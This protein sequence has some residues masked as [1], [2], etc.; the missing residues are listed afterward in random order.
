MA[1]FF[2]PPHWQLPK[3][4]K[5]AFSLRTGGH[6][7]PPYASNNLGLHV[8]DEKEAVLRNREKLTKELG[9]KQVQWLNQVHGSDVCQALA[10]GQLPDVDACFTT[11]SNLACAVLTADCL[12]VLFCNKAGTQV[13]A[14]HAGWRGLA[15]GI[16][17]NTLNTFANPSE[18]YTYLGPAIGPDT[19]E[20]G[21]EVKAA[22]PWASDD[23]FKA[24]KDDRLLANLYQL[25]QQQLEQ[26]GV[27][28]VFVPEAPWCTVQQSEQFFSYRRDGVTGR[29]ASLIWRT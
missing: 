20:V 6:S 11:E 21:P 4:V 27:A 18:V 1:D 3:G 10:D 2:F 5:A 22:F 29:M 17:T 8:G 13:A 19:F 24:G 12:P 23:C 25:A 14:A 16:L 15:A 28:K 26:L 9:V 7:K